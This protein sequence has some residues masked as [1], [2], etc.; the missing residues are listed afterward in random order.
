MI[1]SEKNLLR[2]IVVGLAFSL[3]TTLASAEVAEGTVLSKS[4]IDQLYEDSF[5]GHKIKDLLTEKMEMMIRDFDMVMRLEKSTE[6]KFPSHYWD[7]G[8]ANQGKATLG[9]DGKSVEGFVAGIPFADITQ[10]DPMAGWKLEWNHFYANPLIGDSWAALG[11]VWVTTNEGGVIDNFEAVS[12]KAIMEGRTEGEANI[13]GDKDHARYLLVL[14]EPYD[15]KGLGVFT[16]QYN[17]G[18]LDDGWVY[19]KNLRRTRRTA[20]GKA[21]M[22][23][24]PKMDLLN[25]DNQT[26]LGFPAF[27]Q[28]FKV[29]GK[30]WILAVVN[31]PDPNVAHDPKDFVDL[32]NPPHWVPTPKANP[33]QPR[34]VWIVEATPPEEHPYG[35]KVMYMDVNFPMYYLAE[36]YDKKGDFWRIWRQS[37]SPSKTASGE[38]TLAFIMTQA[39]D[40][41]RQRA[42][43]INIEYMFTNWL[44]QK[45]FDQ[46]VLKKA[47]SGA[48]QKELESV[49]QR[50]LKN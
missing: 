38:P 28:D 32:D 41:Q 46:S 37:Y 1:N 9:A 18:K 12:A 11:D 48:F 31:A 2:S 17:N 15:A 44:E 33:W 40:F 50:Y 3:S 25:D 13:A 24:Q 22:D 42:T 43:F 27:Y 6:V 36:I 39:I 16:K 30:R 8:K 34:E 14:T 5:N 47:A 29:I 35:K 26:V 21:W 23:P 20:G 7:A 19:I 10:D 4:N 45:W 49:R